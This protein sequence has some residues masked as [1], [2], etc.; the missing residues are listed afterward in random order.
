M[1]HS[2]LKR[3]FV[4]FMAFV[5]LAGSFTVLPTA[6]ETS[7]DGT[8]YAGGSLDDY[9]HNNLAA[10]D[11]GFPYLS[12]LDRNPADL[13]KESIVIDAVKYDEEHTDATVE[14]LKNFEGAEGDV[15]YMGDSGVTSWK[16][17]VPETARYAIRITYFPIAEK[18]GIAIPTYTTIERT[19]YIDGFIPFSEARY[20]YFPRNWKYTDYEK[21][22]DGTCIFP[23]D[24][25]GNDIRPIRHQAPEWQ[26]YYLRDW[27]GY[28][29]EPFQFTLTAGEHV[30]SFE[31]NREPIVISKIELYPYEGEPTYEEFLAEKTA[32]GVKIIEKAQK[33]IK[34]QAEDPTLLSDASLFPTNDRTSSLTE[35]QNPQKIRYNILNSGTVN[36]WIKYTV[37]VPEAGLYRIAIRFRQN[38]LIGMFTSRRILINNELQFAEASR[39][40]FKYDSSWQTKFSGDGEQEFL[41]YFEEGENTVTFETVL[42][43]MT[44]YVYEIGN[45]INDLNVA[46]KKILQLTGPIPD[47]NRDYGFT[48]LVPDAIKTIIKASEDLYRIAD[49][50]EAV[51]GELGD[52]V[53]TLN[54]I[55]KLF[56]KMGDEYKIAPNFLTF[57]NYIIALSNWLYA[58][59]GQPLKLDYF[60]IQGTEDA[61]PKAVP[62][63][64][65]VIWFEIRAFI[66]SF[67]MDYTTVDFKT[68]E[69]VTFE[70]DMVIEQWMGSALG[71][72]GAL[73]SR[74]LI[75]EY[76]TNKT[77]IAVKM[78]VITT[79]LTEAILAGIGPDIAG[80]SSVDTITWGLRNAV[81]PLDEFDGF[82][83]YN[84]P[85]RTIYWGEDENEV[86]VDWFP[87]AAI[88]P[89]QMVD[90]RGELHTYGLPSAM[91]FFMM[92]YRSD[93]LYEQGVKVPKTWDDLYD[94]LPALQAADLEVGLPGGA[95]GAVDGLVSLKIFLYQM[96]GSL[97]TEGGY[98]IG[99]DQNVAL[100][101][102]EELCGLVSKYKCPMQFDFTRFR[103]GEIPIIFGMAVSTYNT[104]MSY[105]DIRG[106]WE[107]APL[108]GVEDQFG[109]IN[110]TS[111]L[112]VAS[113]VIPRGT[114]NPEATWEYMMFLAC[115][116]TQK[117]YAKEQIMVN[118]NPTVKYNSCTIE[119]LLEQAWTDEER[120]AIEAQTKQ[121]V[122]IPEYP[123][124]YII[125]TYVNSAFQNVYSTSSDAAE[126]LMD[127]VVYINKEIARKR[128][129]FKMD[130]IDIKG[131]YH[132]GRY[133]TNPLYA[134]KG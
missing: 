11:A 92:F 105:Y 31:A 52:Q 75:D 16:I 74:G 37:N 69:G 48:R 22:A 3:L 89:M 44:T 6:A 20:F 98:A 87:E 118:A 131:K 106:L 101:A 50:L 13:A 93:V 61:K 71:R 115:P 117:L 134:N 54:T 122:G 38:S 124:N 78:K 97:Y 112:S 19:L 66:G 104:L 32:Q 130:Y 2:K 33:I 90:A 114:T 43:D 83:E 40:R 14:V 95:V 100:D 47:A 63:F 62:N 9:L 107:M 29:M 67:F 125:G 41:F 58:S 110:H 120:A 72:D 18:D 84:N 42:G 79:G 57:K 96:G 94:I 68:E 113:T 85:N 46:Y 12:Y 88:V 36:Q 129:D 39:I 51:T 1:Q 28:T 25:T 65:E 60:T 17:N 109:N 35:P 53:A 4:G 77:G 111:F 34:V 121:L 99:L 55:A 80:M 30:L 132:S 91:D 76:F 126:Q 82:Y 49:E 23:T 24:A 128:D 64:F 127:R 27:L 70:R 45:M 102:F 56:A 116:T 123:G 86:A 59:I 73:I 108:L 21:R 5:L 81:E 26:T 7:S 133:Y 15:L 10:G 103:T 119:A 8:L